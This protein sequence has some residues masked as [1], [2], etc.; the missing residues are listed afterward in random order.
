MDM[1]GLAIMDD[2]DIFSKV[3]S[4][5]R[6]FAENDGRGFKNQYTKD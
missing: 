1:K 2:E 3:E 4:E 5:I 6:S